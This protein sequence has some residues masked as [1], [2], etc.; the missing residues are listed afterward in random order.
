MSR[1]GV[2]LSFLVSAG[3][4]IAL[5]VQGLFIQE[6]IS[7]FPSQEECGIHNTINYEFAS[8]Q[9]NPTWFRARYFYVDAG[10]PVDIDL[11]TKLHKKWIYLPTLDIENKSTSALFDSAPPQS[12]ILM[13]VS[14]VLFFEKPETVLFQ[15]QA[16]H[17]LQMYID[18]ALLESDQEVILS[19]GLHHWTARI[20]LSKDLPLNMSFAMKKSSGGSKENWRAGEDHGFSF[21]FGSNRTALRL[22]VHKLFSSGS[23]EPSPYADDYIQ[24]L[25]FGINEGR[26]LGRIVIEVHNKDGG[27]PLSQ[28]RALEIAKELVERGSPS[29]LI[30]VQG[31]GSHWLHESSD[32]YIDIL[33]LH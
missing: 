9:W 11:A 13:E 28:N 33:L 22:P 3:F 17:P 5:V 29:K 32:G 30:T 2:V 24:D 21:R 19:P 18:G 8:D 15:A 25:W 26:F 12:D 20:R 27:I 16:D 1:K 4:G 7:M 23:V 14:E 6:P 10:T 31:Y